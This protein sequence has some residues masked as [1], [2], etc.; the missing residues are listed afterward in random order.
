MWIELLGLESS[1][2]IGSS[3]WLVGGDFNK[4]FHP[5]EDSQPD[6]NQLT[7][8]M[9]DFKPCIDQIEMRDL[10]YYGT[11]FSWANKQPDNSI[12]KK[13]DRALINEHWLG[14]FP[15]SL[16]KFLAPEISDHTLCCLSLDNQIP[17]GGTKPFK[18]FNY[19]TTHPDFLPTVI[20]SWF[21]SG[22][23]DHSLATMNAKQK[24]LKIILKNLNRD[25]FSDIQKRVTEAKSHYNSAQVLSLQLPTSANFQAKRNCLEKLTMLKRIEEESFKQISRINWLLTGD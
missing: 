7:T 13:L 24:Q 17:L 11:R 3:P 23:E 1:L 14:Y 12:A 9:I 25:N 18:F 19:L 5:S 4:I 15:R 2:L 10:H 20:S 16:A 21:C 8:P 22:R 6:N